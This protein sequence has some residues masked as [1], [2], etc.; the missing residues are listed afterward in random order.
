MS[1][2][3]NNKDFLEQ[4]IKR[5]NKCPMSGAQQPT[6]YEMTD[7]NL[8]EATFVFNETKRVVQQ[9]PY[10]HSNKGIATTMEVDYTTGKVNVYAPMSLPSHYK[11]QINNDARNYERRARVAVRLLKKAQSKGLKQT[12][13]SIAIAPTLLNLN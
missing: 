4:T 11:G 9:A 7:Q 6:G 10:H 5:I 12:D 3:S 2:I 13:S 8:L 1:I